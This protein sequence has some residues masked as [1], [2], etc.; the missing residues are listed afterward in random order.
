MHLHQAVVQPGLHLQAGT[1]LDRHW[2]YIISFTPQDG[3]AA[4]GL[5]SLHSLYMDR[6]LGVINSAAVVRKGREERESDHV[7]KTA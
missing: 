2:L 3:D 4:A 5:V 1:S 7:P 6:P